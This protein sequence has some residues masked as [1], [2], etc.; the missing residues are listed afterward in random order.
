M[1]P[2]QS[3]S[4]AQW[5]LLP[6]KGI[7]NKEK[8]LKHFLVFHMFFSFKRI[9]KAQQTFG[10]GKAG[11]K[12]LLLQVRMFWGLFSIDILTSEKTF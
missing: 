10:T 1:I 7:K 6:E 8:N 2:G 5:N 11:N 4:V 12:E 3:Y 9:V